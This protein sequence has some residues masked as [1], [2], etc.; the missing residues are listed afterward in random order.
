MERR[1]EL[2]FAPF[3]SNKYSYDAVRYP[4]YFEVLHTSILFAVTTPRRVGE[5]G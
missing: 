5:E 2:D 3:Q 1:M 4:Y